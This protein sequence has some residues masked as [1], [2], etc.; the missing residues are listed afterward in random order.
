MHDQAERVVV[1]SVV[2]YVEM[3]LSRQKKKTKQN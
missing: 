1:L 2:G 3:E